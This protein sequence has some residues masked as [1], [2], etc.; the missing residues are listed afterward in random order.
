MHCEIIPQVGNKKAICYLQVWERLGND[1]ISPSVKSIPCCHVY[2]GP[3][4]LQCH[5]ERQT[6][7]AVEN[8]GLELAQETERKPMPRYHCLVK[9]EAFPI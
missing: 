6:E 7:K 1:G 9:L 5:S 8:R 2:P 3:K 4:C